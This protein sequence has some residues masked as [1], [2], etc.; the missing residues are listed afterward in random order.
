MS[1]G[2]S[3]PS[4]R[5][6]QRHRQL[7]DFRS[8]PL[9]CDRRVRR[10]RGHPCRCNFWRKPVEQYFRFSWKRLDDRR[11]QVQWQRY[12]RHCG[13][14]G[15]WTDVHSVRRSSVIDGRWRLRVRRGYTSVPSA[16]GFE[17]VDSGY[18]IWFRSSYVEPR[19]GSHRL[20]G[21]LPVDV[22]RNWR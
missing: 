6:R 10:C 3:A 18:G 1:M 19:F 7:A 8:C 9:E 13:K 14:P 17:H 20:R 16:G 12:G 21:T 4:G 15:F 5:L 11:C 2:C 22:D